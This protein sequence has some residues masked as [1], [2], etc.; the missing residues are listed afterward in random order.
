MLI[1]RPLT[2]T[3]VAFSVPSWSIQTIDF[4]LATI[5]LL[6]LRMSFGDTC[7]CLQFWWA[8]QRLQPIFNYRVQYLFYDHLGR[9]GLEFWRLDSKISEKSSIIYENRIQRSKLRSVDQRG[10]P[11]RYRLNDIR[12]FSVKCS[13]LFVLINLL[14]DS[15]WTILAGL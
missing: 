3:C 9:F 11:C 7:F 8:S 12:F 13:I 15:V 14:T 4:R 5:L 2:R 10:S 1:T 6:L